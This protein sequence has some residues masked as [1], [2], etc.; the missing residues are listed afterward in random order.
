M[1]AHWKLTGVCILFS[2]MAH[3]QLT[4]SGQLRTRTEWR[5]GQGTPSVQDTAAAFFTSQRTRF[6]VGFAA[7][8]VKF[9]SSIQ[10]VRVWGQDAS[11]VNRAT[12]D[13]N[14]GLMVHEA[15]TEVA[16]VDTGRAIN[17]LSFKLG[18]QELVYDDVRLLGNLDW[19]QQ[20]RR[21]DALLF[22]LEHQGWIAHLGAGFNQNGERKSNTIY[23]GV[24][25][26]YPAGTNGIGAMYKSMQF[27]YFGRK[28]KLTSWSLL[29]FKDD[30]SKFHF[31]GTDSLK[32]NPIY[33]RE[34]WSRVTT[35]AYITT[36][37]INK[38]T[39]T[40][41]AYYQGGRYRDG[42]PL[43]EYLLSAYSMYRITPK[44]AAGPGVD[45]TSG[46]N[47]GDPSKR[48]QRFDPLYGTP[49]KFWGYMDYF[50][51]ADGFGPSGLVDIYFRGSHKPAQDLSLFLD[52]HRFSLPE[53]VLDESGNAMNKILGTEVDFTFAWK[54]LE[55]VTLDG[56][57]CYMF[58]TPT[59]MSTKVKNIKNADPHS[60]WAYLMLSI[61]P[62][63]VFQPK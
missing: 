22:T 32:K 16:L 28:Q 27:L 6:N 43:N 12:S 36:S 52:I 17:N 11:T 50:Y 40:G 13:P 41:S 60:A 62:E 15:W 44:F 21:H 34:V 59:L 31:A 29:L 48:S 9:Y 30:F 45:I 4:V 24:P 46:N 23:N 2:L 47:G 54:I 56:G 58:G 39:F 14:D 63:F 49:H 37:R 19:L 8:R 51:V 35:G 26:G 53:A 55:S 10:D 61:R 3:G 57:M 33:E 5:D 38:L 25:V 42:T 18:R 7:H 1:K 20:G